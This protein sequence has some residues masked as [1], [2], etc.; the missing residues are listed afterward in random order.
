M[1]V[2]CCEINLE[3]V[4]GELESELEFFEPVP[5]RFI[6][7]AKQVMFR[8]CTTRFRFGVQIWFR[9]QAH[10]SARRYDNRD[11]LNSTK[12]NFDKTSREF[13]IKVRTRKSVMQ[14]SGFQLSLGEALRMPFPRQQQMVLTTTQISTNERTRKGT[15][16]S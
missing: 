2:L 7:F 12:A 15:R 14:P 4:N 8:L 10:Y 5:L 16:E 3:G 13:K 9:L 1:W 11:G 6:S